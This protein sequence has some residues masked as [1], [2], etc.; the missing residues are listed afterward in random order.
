M[1]STEVIK[2]QNIGYSLLLAMR[3]KT[4]TAAVVPVF[5]GTMIAVGQEIAI[6]WSIVCF[7]L[8]SALC[9]QIGTN[10]INDALDF[11]KGA[12]TDTRLGPMRVT[13]SGLLSMQ[14]VIIVGLGFFFLALLFGIPL[15]Q[16][17]GN[18]I[19]ILLVISV[20]CGYLYT[21]GPKPLAYNGFGDLFVFL[22]FGLISTSAMYYLQAGNL[23]SKPI[24]AGA[25]VGLLATVLIAVNNLRDIS[26]DAKVNK[27]TLAVRFGKRF[28]R[29]EIT[30]LILIPFFLSVFWWSFN[31]N[32]AAL[33]PWFSFPL[34]YKLI[35]CIWKTEP[36]P[37][38]NHF[39]VQAAAL[40]LIF[41]LLLG[42]SLFTHVA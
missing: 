18:P 35:G 23:D 1:K 32:L 26:G 42:L 14:Q 4:L 16:R 41:G 8:L 28:A 15:I 21:G 29:W 2:K 19:A 9:I 12:D 11:K 17:G 31:D 38:Y 27:K 22:F 24:L 3:P 40:H 7:A 6:A 39:L 5:V 36:S 30:L 13:Q 20:L 25:Q 33:L 10:F 34:G 37:I